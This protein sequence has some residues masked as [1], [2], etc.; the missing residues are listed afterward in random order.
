[1]T[2]LCLV[3][4]VAALVS[5]GGQEPVSAPPPPPPPP[6]VLPAP[7]PVDVGPKPAPGAEKSLSERLLAAAN[8]P[9]TAEA[10]RHPDGVLW[11]EFSEAHEGERADADGARKQSRQWCKP[12]DVQRELARALRRSE[13]DGDLSCDETKGTCTIAGHHDAPDR[14]FIFQDE[15]LREIQVLQRAA[16]ADAWLAKVDAYVAKQRE[17]LAVKT[18]TRKKK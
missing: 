18:C 4:V 13:A 17:A 7:A 9:E 15:R 14:M 12:Q 16:M 6:V 11:I 3:F 10:L 2:R 1:M 8:A 5:C